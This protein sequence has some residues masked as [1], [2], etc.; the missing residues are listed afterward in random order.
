MHH[1]YLVVV[2]AIRQY[3]EVLTISADNTYD[4]RSVNYKYD[5]GASEG[6]ITFPRLRS[7]V[8]HTSL[9]LGTMSITRECDGNDHNPLSVES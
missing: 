2:Q 5:R 8:I 7:P 9:S 4:C 3:I 1:R 6:A